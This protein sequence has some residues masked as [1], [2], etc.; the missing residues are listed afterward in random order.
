LPR[1]EEYILGLSI[2]NGQDLQ[3]W[4]DIFK[5]EFK[6]WNRCHYLVSDLSG[7]SGQIANRP[8]L[9]FDNIA[10]K[11]NFQIQSIEQKNIPGSLSVY[12][13]NFLTK[14]GPAYAK[15]FK[16]IQ[17]LVDNK[18]LVTPV[19]I[20]LQTMLE[21]KL[22]ITNFN[23]CV[24]VYNKWVEEK[25]VGTPYTSDDINQGIKEEIQRWHTV[26]QLK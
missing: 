8:Q 9:T 12:D 16:A 5:I 2:F 11:N 4:K 18:V 3:S 7:I 22:L 15:S 23:Q 1:I 6:D 26:P 24:D 25:G 14:Q 17:E 21:K 10:S 20:K 19:P 13:R